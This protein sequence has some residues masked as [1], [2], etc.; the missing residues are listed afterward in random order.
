MLPR[1]LR[2]R[3]LAAAALAALLSA[4][5]AVAAPAPAEQAPPKPDQVFSAN[6]RTGAVSPTTGIVEANRLDKVVILQGDKSRDVDATLVVRI[7]FGDVPPSYRDGTAYFERGDFAQSAES[8]LLA[9]GDASARPVVQA[10]AR[11]RAAEALMKSGGRDPAAF[12][13]AASEASTFL[14]DHPTNREVPAARILPAR[15]NMLA[16]RPADAADMYRLIFR[17]G[18][19]ATPTPGYSWTQCMSAGLR[20]AQA[21]LA[22]KNTEKGHELRIALDKALQRV[23]GALPADDA[24]RA[25]L[26]RIHDQARLLD[27]WSLLASGSASQAKTFFR[28]QLT[29]AGSGGSAALVRGA[30]LGLAEALLAEGDVRAAQILFARVSALDY[31]DRDRTAQ[32]MLGAALCAKKLS[33]AD[34]RTD[35]RRWLE[36][37]IANY[38]DT[39]AARTARAEL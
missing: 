27:G 29:S 13:R 28:G 18:E 15:A 20:C 16:G 17:E 25:E 26:T 34:S 36:A 9:A 33:D 11:L 3:R 38:G 39:P 1:P 32:A 2:N 23:L 6:R 14:A 12:P 10:A 4:A 8:F 21:Y 7:V 37:V 31:V 19:N 35:A 5:P 22:A 30:E 24:E